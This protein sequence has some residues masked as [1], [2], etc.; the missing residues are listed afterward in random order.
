MGRSDCR[1]PE[2]LNLSEDGR[3]RKKMGRYKSSLEA[4][5]LS[6]F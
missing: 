3:N 1:A 4:A 2:C 6:I 5:S